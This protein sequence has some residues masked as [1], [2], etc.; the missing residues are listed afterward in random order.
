M[1]TR[2]KDRFGQYFTAGDTINVKPLKKDFVVFENEDSELCFKHELTYLEK[3]YIF[4]V[5][6]QPLENITRVK[7]KGE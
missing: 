4:R 1:T 2:L 6:D 5:S 3:P 7:T